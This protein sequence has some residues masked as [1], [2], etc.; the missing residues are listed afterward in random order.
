MN[1]MVVF[2]L[3]STPLSL[4]F[5]SASAKS[6]R[7]PQNR[8]PATVK[9]EITAG[10]DIR[11][12]ID[13]YITQ[14]FQAVE[15]VR[16]VEDHPHWTVKVVTMTGTDQ[17][18]EMMAVGLSVVVLEHGPEMEILRTLTQAW[19]YILKAGLLQKDQPLEISMRDLVNGIDRLPRDK[20]VTVLRQHRMCLIPAAKLP[21][22]C[23]DIVANFVTRYLQ[24][25]NTEPGRTVARPGGA[26][27]AAVLR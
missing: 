11:A 22:A 16:L 12:A 27:I 2:L 6:A 21:E 24:S 23:R 25:S 4:P 15:G 19:H 1:P 9:I 14:G 18:G 3:C 26:G 8:P 20:E 13:T 5:S 10:D 17:T 7:A